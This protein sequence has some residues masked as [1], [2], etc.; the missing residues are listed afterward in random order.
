MEF[1]EIPFYMQFAFHHKDMG[2]VS[3]TNH[4]PGFDFAN[5]TVRTAE[6]IWL[7]IQLKG[8][9]LVKTAAVLHAIA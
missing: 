5:R 4:T 2:F 6:C 7:N 9:P 1:S 3:R 8:G